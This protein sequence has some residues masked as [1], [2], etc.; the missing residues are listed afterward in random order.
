MV[1]EEGMKIAKNMSSLLKSAVNNDSLILSIN[2]TDIKPDK[3][4]LNISGP[5]RFCSRGQVYKDGY[6]CKS[7]SL[8]A[9]IIT[10]LSM[11][12]IK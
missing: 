4:S 5:K 2:G 10:D 3:Q 6:C 1:G 12:K 8:L 9:T 11:R 7:E